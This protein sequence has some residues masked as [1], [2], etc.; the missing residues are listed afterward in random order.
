MSDRWRHVTADQPPDGKRV[1][2]KWPNEAE[3]PLATR[4]NCAQM[5]QKNLPAADA[6]WYRVDP[7]VRRTPRL[8]C[9][10]YWQPINAPV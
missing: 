2:V 7:G 5:H 3:T 10:V 8:T 9:P 4:Y 6:G 1:R